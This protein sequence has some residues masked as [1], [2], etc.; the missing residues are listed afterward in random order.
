MVCSKICKQDSSRQGQNLCV[1][2][3]AA[4]K[5]MFSISQNLLT[6]LN[7]RRIC[8]RQEWKFFGTAEE[9]WLKICCKEENVDFDD[10]VRVKVTL[11]EIHEY[12]LLFD[13]MDSGKN[14]EVLS[15]S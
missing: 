3:L 12:L 5:R 11:Q 13:V 9:F 1:N 4:N 10:F 8:K 7:I 14:W 15:E 6:M 2:S